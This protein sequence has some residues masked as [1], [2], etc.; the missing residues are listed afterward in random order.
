[1]LN[2][3]LNRFSLW[4]ICTPQWTP[5]PL[6]MHRK[7]ALLVDDKQKCKP[8]PPTPKELET[9]VIQ[10]RWSRLTHAE[11]EIGGNTEVAREKETP[12]RGRDDG[13]WW[14]GA[15]LPHFPLS[16]ARG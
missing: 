11:K 12:V 6:P 5:T 8:P 15:E 16:T 10:G 2:Y 7:Q 14:E 1:M 9:I 4:T 3:L 13:E